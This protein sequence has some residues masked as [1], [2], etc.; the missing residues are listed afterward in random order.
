ME[1]GNLI[2][3]R[4]PQDPQAFYPATKGLTVRTG[5]MLVS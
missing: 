2:G 3:Q 5:D 1:S 4:S